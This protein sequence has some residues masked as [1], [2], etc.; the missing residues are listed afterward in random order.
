MFVQQ[1]LPF[2][3]PKDQL[4]NL[5]I[6]EIPSIIQLAKDLFKKNNPDAPQPTSE[7]VIAAYQ[8]GLQSSL[9]KDAAW[10]AAHPE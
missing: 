7:E 6:N 3:N 1:E 2:M 10:L 8:Q 9:D 4:V 5:V